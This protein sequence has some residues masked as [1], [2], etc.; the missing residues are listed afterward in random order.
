MLIWILRCKCLHSNFLIYNLYYLRIEQIKTQLPNPADNVIV[1]ISQSMNLVQVI[2]PPSY[3]PSRECL[4]D[5]RQGTK[6]DNAVSNF[7]SFCKHLIY[8]TCTLFSKTQIH[9]EQA[10]IEGFKNFK[11]CQNILKPEKLRDGIKKLDNADLNA[12]LD[13]FVQNCAIDAELIPSNCNFSRILFCLLLLSW[14]IRVKWKINFI[15]NQSG[16]ISKRHR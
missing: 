10:E 11:N 1:S 13:T 4:C 9:I 2:V 8:F 3:A 7:L 12:R 16:T 15:R 6:I 14:I 5:A